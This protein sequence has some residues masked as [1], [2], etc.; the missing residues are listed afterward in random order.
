MVQAALSWRSEDESAMNVDGNSTLAF[1]SLVARVL[2][3]DGSNAL[4]VVVALVD[5]ETDQYSAILASGP[6]AV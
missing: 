4:L 2:G 3:H 6:G 5:S 1:W